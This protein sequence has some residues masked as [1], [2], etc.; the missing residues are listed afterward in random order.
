MN[1][2]RVPDKQPWDMLTRNLRMLSGYPSPIHDKLHKHGEKLYKK[3]WIQFIVSIEM[4][5]NRDSKDEA[6]LLLLTL[7]AKASKCL[8]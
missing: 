8:L 7:F 6:P 1:S 5:K 4:H 3:C 2:L